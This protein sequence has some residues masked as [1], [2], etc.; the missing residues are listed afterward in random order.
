MHCFF[1]GYLGDIGPPCVL[2]MKSSR[3]TSTCVRAVSRA[4]GD[5]DSQFLSESCVAVA[6][7]SEVCGVLVSAKSSRWCGGAVWRLARVSSVLSL[8]VLV[9]AQKKAADY[10]YSMGIHRWNPNSCSS[11]GVAFGTRNATDGISSRRTHMRI[12]A[13]ARSNLLRKTGPR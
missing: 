1:A 3:Y 9:V 5:R 12:Y 11:S 13:S 7:S 4:C 2:P 8:T 10:T 6:S